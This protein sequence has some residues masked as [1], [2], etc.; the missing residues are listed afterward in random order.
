MLQD[1]NQKIIHFQRTGN[2]GQI[3]I[4]AD[5]LHKEPEMKNRAF[6][7]VFVWKK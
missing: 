3:I 4:S 6:Q 5:I 2:R 1:F 7:T